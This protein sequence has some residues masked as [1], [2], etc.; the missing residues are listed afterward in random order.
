MPDYFNIMPYELLE[1]IFSKTGNVF[2]R[3]KL[4]Y[5]Y[6]FKYQYTYDYDSN[7]IHELTQDCYGYN[8]RMNPKYPILAQFSEHNS[9][10][11][12]LYDMGKKIDKDYIHIKGYG[13]DYK[14]DKHIKSSDLDCTCGS[15][16]VC[17]CYKI[18]MIRNIT[19]SICGRYLY[20]QYTRRPIIHIIDIFTTEK[21]TYKTNICTD[22]SPSVYT[23]YKTKTI[24]LTSHIFSRYYLTKVLKTKFTNGNTRASQ[25]KYINAFRKNGVVLH[26]ALIDSY[27]NIYDNYN[28]NYNKIVKIHTS[29]P[30][31]YRL[32]D[33]ILQG[34][35]LH[36]G[37]QI[38]TTSYDGEYIAFWHTISLDDEPKPYFKLN[39]TELMHNTTLDTK[40]YKNRSWIAKLD[41]S[42]CGT[43]LAIIRTDGT[44]CIWNNITNILCYISSGTN[45]IYGYEYEYNCSYDS[46]Q[47]KILNI[48][49]DVGRHKKYKKKTVMNLVTK[50]E[51]ICS[52]YLSISATGAPPLIWNSITHCVNRIDFGLKYKNYI[53]NRY[54]HISNP[55]SQNAIFTWFGDSRHILITNIIYNNPNNH[56]LYRSI[57]YDCDEDKLLCI[58]GKN[59]HIATNI[60]NLKILDICRISKTCIKLA[61]INIFT[62]RMDDY[63]KY[64]SLYTIELQ[65]KHKDTKAHTHLETVEWNNQ[66]YKYQVTD[67]TQIVGITHKEII[68]LSSNYVD[69]YYINNCH[70]SKYGKIIL[71]IFVKG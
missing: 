26:N 66:I 31:S 41:W 29:Y 38:Y 39:I 37:Q 46:K 11:I 18:N 69:Y 16:D 4:H 13:C 27:H 6:G 49:N 63:G 25:N 14:V 20:I 61:M 7:N 43:Y 48:S 65:D 22:A 9:N 35:A 40:D 3:Y 30:T 59:G 47:H 53:K 15:G 52:A 68:K 17:M 36:P 24:L 67:N 23:K 1:L 58:M 50:W 64:L 8:N 70:I 57:V 42:P 10:G 33:I 19:W 51:P 56:E 32:Q 62:S 21:H 60:W 12:C 34:F 5:M 44:W 45:N 71:N 55:N 54:R 2:D 28:L